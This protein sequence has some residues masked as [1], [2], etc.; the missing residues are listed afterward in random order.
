MWTILVGSIVQVQCGERAAAV[1]PL[2]GSH[3]LRALT[4]LS[5]P[6]SIVLIHSRYAQL[7]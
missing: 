1:R 4:S 6:E 3:R 2:R 7:E 5:V